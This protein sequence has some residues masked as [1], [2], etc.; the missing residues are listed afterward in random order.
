MEEISDS[1]VFL[2]PEMEEV[3]GPEAVLPVSHPTPVT[4]TVSV[5]E[6]ADDAQLRPQSPLHAGI[7]SMEPHVHRIA[8]GTGAGTSRQPYSPHT[9]SQ[10]TFT[11][12]HRQTLPTHTASL[13]ADHIRPR[14]PP[15]FTGE[16]GQD[17]VS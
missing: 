11:Q 16:R 9:R 12:P 10:W 6:A 14:K 5:S 8:S 13:Y 3:M 2:Y 1:L 15:V 7:L 4:C 17:F